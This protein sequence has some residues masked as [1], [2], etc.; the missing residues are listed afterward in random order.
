MQ[1]SS[2]V[3]IIHGTHTTTFIK[4]CQLRLVRRHRGEVLHTLKTTSFHISGLAKCPDQSHFFYWDVSWGFQ[5]SVLQREALHAY[6]ST[7]RFWGNFTH[8]STAVSGQLCQRLVLVYNISL[9]V[10]AWVHIGTRVILTVILQQSYIKHRMLCTRCCVNVSREERNRWCWFGQ[11]L[12]I[13]RVLLCAIPLSRGLRIS[14]HERFCKKSLDIIYLPYLFIHSSF[15]TLL[16]TTHWIYQKNKHLL[17]TWKPTMDILPKVL[18]RD[19][20]FRDH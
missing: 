2:G 14:S 17:V 5:Y 18:H 11:T 13:T 7:A 20:I 6:I 1:L 10:Q 16:D 4:G 8:E 9:R 12:N 15:H 3:P 19:L